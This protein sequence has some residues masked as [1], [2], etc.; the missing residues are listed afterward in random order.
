M[1][2]RKRTTKKAAPRRRRT[3]TALSTTRRT[4]SVKRR[5]TRRK[6]LAADFFTPAAAK[7]AGMIVVEGAAGGVGAHFL[8]KLLPTTLSAQYRGLLTI[9]AGFVTA[10]MFKRPILGAGMAAVGTI[11]L[12]KEVNFLA[13]D[14]LAEWSSGMESLPMVLNEGEA[15]ALSE[16]YPLSEDFES[17]G[18]DYE[19]GYYPEF[20]GM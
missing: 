2:K 7:E 19:V 12:L 1:Y 14:N 10:A 15:Y 9:G 8:G 17:A 13:D 16:M 20:G 4:R 5:A 11:N 3:T 6:G 18:T